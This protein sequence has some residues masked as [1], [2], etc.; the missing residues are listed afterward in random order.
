MK[1]YF[2]DQ[3]ILWGLA[4]LILI[5]HILTN[6]FGAYGYFRDELYYIACSD[7]LAFGYVD[8][9]P[10][11]ILL[12]AVNRLLFGDSIV[13]LRL[14]PA[15]SHALVVFLTGLLAKEFGGN[16]FSQVFAAIA[17]LIAPVYLVIFNFYSMNAFDILLWALAILIVV[18]IIQTS[19]SSLWILFGIIAGIGL[20]NKLSMLFLIF[21][22]GV[23]L[24]LTRH[25]RQL[26]SRWF[27][28]G[29]AIAFLIFLPNILWQMKN[30]WPTLEFMHNAT[31][32]KNA[33]TSF[34]DFLSGQFEQMHPFAVLL[35]LP[36]LIYLLASRRL[37]KYRLFAF[38]YLAIFLIF[39]IQNGKAYY[40]SPI[41]PVLFAAGSILADRVLNRMLPAMTKPAIITIFVLGGIFLAPLSLTMLPVESFIQYTKMLGIEIESEERDNPGKLPQHYADMFGWPEMTATVARVYENLDLRE[42]ENC[43]IFAQNYGQAGALEFFGKKY[44][45]PPVI[46]GHNNYWLWG[47]G[48][49]AQPDVVIVIA[50]NPADYE[51]LFS[52]YEKAAIIQHKY[53][54]AF[55][56]NLPVYVCRGLK[57][58]VKEV[59][60]E[61]RHYM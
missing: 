15:I 59:W 25:R 1:K 49:M 16:R 51:E 37:G 45:L 32:Y 54:R 18:K 57:V 34:I 43:V 35:W 14:L 56:T 47:P 21:G 30:D 22:T 41:Y 58:A 23:G 11:S 24:L 55:E 40:L 7:R 48:M 19:K 20:Q 29:A 46:S 8:Q 28:L 53:A 2:S 9:P 52:S 44:H 33:P 61:T 38:A 12:L 50:G 27:W 17:A 36:G 13:A 5:I 10:F 26:L 4:F 31:V 39:V 42:K 6:A 3:A 60:A